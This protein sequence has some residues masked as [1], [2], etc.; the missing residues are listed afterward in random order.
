MAMDE[1][2]FEEDPQQEEA[3][4]EEEEESAAGEDA[5]Y[6]DLETIGRDDPEEPVVPVEDIGEE[7][8]GD[9]DADADLI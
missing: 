8:V 4:V 3:V 9:A 6:P 2:V 7:I 5:F 1:D